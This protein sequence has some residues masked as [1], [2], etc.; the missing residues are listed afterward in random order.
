MILTCSQMSLAEYLMTPCGMR[1][2]SRS[3]SDIPI[4][5]QSGAKTLMVTWWSVS[6]RDIFITFG[7]IWLQQAHTDASSEHSV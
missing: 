2:H 1:G 4:F 7:H 5:V 3:K 6:E